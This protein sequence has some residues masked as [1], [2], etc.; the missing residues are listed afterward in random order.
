M[1]ELLPAELRRLGLQPV[2]RLDK[3]T[4]GLLL[5]TNDGDFAHRVISP[6]SGVVKTYLARTQGD[7]DAEDERGFARGLEL[8]GSGNLR[9]L[10]P[11]EI[12]LVFAH[13][14]RL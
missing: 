5:L 1:L 9:E 14:H 2:G 7:V 4:T 6:K 13:S 12:E 3:D 8:E 11:G 10:F